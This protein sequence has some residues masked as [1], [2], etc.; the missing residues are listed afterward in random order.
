MVSFVAGCE[1]GDAV[2]SQAAASTRR[3]AS[4][5]VIT[6]APAIL[7]SAGKTILS[8]KDW[9]IFDCPEGVSRDSQRKVV[10]AVAAWI[11]DGTVSD[12][13]ANVCSG[14]WL[15]DIQTAG[16]YRITLR[17][18][19]EVS[20]MRVSLRP[21]R[22]Y[23]NCSNAAAEQIITDGEFF[24]EFELELQMGESELEAYFTNQLPDRRKL[25]VMFVGIDRLGE[26]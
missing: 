3:S 12:E 16:T 9:Q 17:L 4:R 19:P 15:V 21:G 23:L 26:E 22:A 18:V 6:I 10:R 14:K 5:P 11:N 2:E 8:Y 24:V 20:D 7:I 1:S 13:L 25:S